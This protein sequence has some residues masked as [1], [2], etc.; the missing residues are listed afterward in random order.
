MTR[1]KTL[2]VAAALVGGLGLASTAQAAPLGASTAGAVAG[3]AAVSNVHYW[4]YGYGGGYYRP[5]PF[6]RPYGYGYYRPRPYYGGYGF[7]RPRPF[8]G[9]G[10]RR[11]F[12]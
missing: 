12:F 4:R 8:Y 3:D 10:F 9:F 11:R 5:R 1:F 2:A 7:Y 6:Y